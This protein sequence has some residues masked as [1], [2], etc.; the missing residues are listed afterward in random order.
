[1]GALIEVS[2]RMDALVSAGIGALASINE[3]GNTCKHKQE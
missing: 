3:N 2:V 1:M